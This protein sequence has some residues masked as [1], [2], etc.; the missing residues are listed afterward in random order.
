MKQS[1]HDLILS[2]LAR[3]YGIEQTQLRCLTDNPEDGVY[4]FTR[5]GQ[6]FVVKYTLETV[7]SFSALQGQ[8][9]LGQFPG[10]ARCAGQSPRAIASGWMGGATADQRHF[11][12]CG[13]L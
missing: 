5:Q 6:A 12:V 13:L 2:Q 11:C 9:D 7:R 10:G 4:G 3:C 8:V 1:E